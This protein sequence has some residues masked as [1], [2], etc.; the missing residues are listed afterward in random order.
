MLTAWDGTLS[1]ASAPAALYE[2]WLPHLQRAFVPLAYRPSDRPHA[3]ER[4][5]FERMLDRLQKPSREDLAALVGPALDAAFREAREKMG[6]RPGEWAWQR[7]HRAEFLH[8]LA[9]TDARRE[10]FNLPPVPRGGDATTVNNTGFAA[11]QVHGASF[12]AVMDVGDWDRSKMIN[13]PGQSGQP[14]SRHYG[15]LLPLW[16]RGEYH[17]MLF[18]REAVEQHAS[19]RLVLR[20]GV[21]ASERPRPYPSPA[22]QQ[23]ATRPVAPADAPPRMPPFAGTLVNYDRRGGLTAACALAPGGGETK[24]GA[25]VIPNTHVWVFE[26]EIVR[27]LGSTPGTCDPVWAPDGSRLAVVAPNGLWTYSPILDDPRLLAETSLPAA[28]KHENDYTAF[29]RPRWSSDGRRI[30]YLVTNGATNWVEA[31]E[32]ATTRRVF[33]SPPGVTVFA[34]GETPDTLVVDGQPLSLPR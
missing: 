7:L 22:E 5:P 17:P 18:S 4:L 26:R 16:Q 2:L 10:V 34:W 21:P 14:G 13:V 9:T 31:L 24:R 27:E 28:P 8:T 33:K 25:R 23:A 3:P 32:V 12:R 30:A 19:A 20:P 29:S 1:G 15:D 6:P 11:V